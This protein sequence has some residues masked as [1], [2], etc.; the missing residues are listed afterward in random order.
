MK[1]VATGKHGP[2]DAEFG[3]TIA[4]KSA[5]WL[6]ERLADGLLDCAYSLEGGGRLVIANA[7]SAEEAIARCAAD[8][9][10]PHVIVLPDAPYTVGRA[11]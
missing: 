8:Y 10:S 11:G 3:K 6:R 2:L 9:A 7:D 4:P 1:F 5:A